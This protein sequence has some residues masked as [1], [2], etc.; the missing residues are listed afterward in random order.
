MSSTRINHHRLAWVDALRGIAALLVA[1]G[2]VPLFMAAPETGGPAADSL[3]HPN[4]GRAGVICFFLISGFVVPFSFRSGSTRP[5]RD[6]LIRRFFRLYPAYWVS[7]LT[8]IAV[9][10]FTQPALL[11]P[12]R[13]AAHVGLVYSF[14]GMLPLQGNYWT[15]AAEIAFYGVCVFLFV[16]KIL[17]RPWFLAAV[18]WLLTGLYA[19]LQWMQATGG[20]RLLTWELGF[21]PYALAVML[22]GT[23]FRKVFDKRPGEGAL[24]AAVAGAGATFGLPLA[25][26][27]AGSLGLYGQ[28]A[29]VS[30]GISHWLGLLIFGATVWLLK[31]PPRVLLAF[32]TVSYSFYLFHPLMVKAVFEIPEVWGLSV[33][34]PLGA[35]AAIG[36][37]FGIASVIYRLV[38]KP[39]IDR[40]KR[41]TKA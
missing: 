28:G 12:A 3:W 35:L 26:L 2:H 21:M 41:L 39:A 6:F 11:D 1:I 29:L 33:P 9:L 15:L 40:G 10:A 22:T 37:D 36:L 8:V 7:L 27:I 31:K 34:Q 38:E 4:L 16:T 25:Q 19:L 20:D 14:L 17:D 18:C 30:T 23:L 24:G 13:V 5:V 32:G